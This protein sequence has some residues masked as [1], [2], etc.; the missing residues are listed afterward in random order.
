M[1]KDELESLWK[2]LKENVSFPNEKESEGI[3]YESFQLISTLLPKKCKQFFL[4]S[5]FMR[6]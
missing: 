6:F 1:D 5:T 4:P 3:N 2:I